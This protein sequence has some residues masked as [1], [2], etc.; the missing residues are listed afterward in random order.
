[1]E[2]VRKGDVIRTLRGVGGGGV[3]DYT[4]LNRPYYC[5]LIMG[6]KAP[7]PAPYPTKGR[8]EDCSPN[9]NGIARPA[10]HRKESHRSSEFYMSGEERERE[11]ESERE[12]E[13]AKNLRNLSQKER[14][15]GKQQAPNFGTSLYIFLQYI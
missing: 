4:S 8:F 9:P 13:R 5:I 3:G 6:I 2:A 7:Y 14:L 10:M 1:M 12:R 15:G 11:R